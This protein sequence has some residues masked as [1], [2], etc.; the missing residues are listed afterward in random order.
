MA[1]IVN[2]LP[3]EAYSSSRNIAEANIDLC[4]IINASSAQNVPMAIC[5]LDFRKAFDSVSNSYAIE[6]FSWMGM[7]KYIV[8]MLKACILGKKGFISNLEN[9]NSTFNIGRGFAQGD[10][11]SG[12][13]FGLCVNLAFF[14]ILKHPLYKDITIPLPVGVQGPENLLSN[15]LVAFDDNSK[16]KRAVVVSN[17]SLLK[18]FFQNLNYLV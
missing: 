2:V 7:P 8:K 13:E 4:N 3:Q 5:A 6:L 10:R 16:A 18:K 15:R 1:D 9:S 17:L 11:P 12:I 14:R